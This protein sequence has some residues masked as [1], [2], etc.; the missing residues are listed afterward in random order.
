M[1][2]PTRPT[3]EMIEQLRRHAQDPAWTESFNKAFGPNA[4]R[5]FLNVTTST[6][7]DSPAGVGADVVRSLGRAGGE[8]LVGTLAAARPTQLYAQGFDETDPMFQQIMAD[9][10]E[11]ASGAPDA[12]GLGGMIDYE[13]QT[14]PGK[15]AYYAA[16]FLPL[17]IGGAM[18]GRPLVAG[19]AALAGA[20]TDAGVVEW[21]DLPREVG[22]VGGSIASM[23]AG[24]PMLR[25]PPGA[26][27]ASEALSGVPE[28]R[29]SDAVALQRSSV[30]EGVPL[31]APEALNE[32]GVIALADAA[33]T[34]PGAAAPFHAITRERENLAR[35]A[36]QTKLDQ[37]GSTDLSPAGVASD[38]TEAGKLIIGGAAQD[39]TR[40][41][42]TAG[43][44]NLPLEHVGPDRVTNLAAMVD[45][46]L[47]QTAGMSG[48]KPLLQKFRGQ[49]FEED[50]SPITNAAYLESAYKQLREGLNR[51][52]S[53]A[54]I[55]PDDAISAEDAG[56]VGPLIDEL[57]DILQEAP[58]YEPG[59]STF[60]SISESTVDPLRAQLEPV[61]GAND[62]KQIRTVMLDPDSVTA[63]ELGPLL[64]TVERKSPSAVPNIARVIFERAYDRAF[65]QR[66]GKTPPTSPARFVDAL[67]N[68][69]I[70]RQKFEEVVSSVAR[71]QGKNPSQV[72]AGWN[73]LLDVLQRTATMPDVGSRTNPRG[74]IQRQAGE[75]LLS[76]G[77][78][79]A[80]PLQVLERATGSRNMRRLGAILADSNGV[81]GLV[82]L[83]QTKPNTAR[84]AYIVNALLQTARVIENA[85]TEQ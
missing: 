8:M 4:A 10:A 3:P 22:S 46:T 80:Q 31:M 33:A 19:G 40:A 67:R 52:T 77:I 35:R 53:G 36:I 68:N 60:E 16:P 13:P 69:G 71:S 29:L 42:Q 74:T 70:Q 72:V 17:A 32:P 47:A 76:Q 65:K 75:T 18:G 14:I 55:S 73:K 45:A 59:R 62:W 15:A 84:A 51:R 85:G 2:A 5:R 48:L 56:K 9:S 20:G 11:Q 66:G 81:Q 57:A 49:L 83:A 6:V 43:Y 23:I 54:L 58:S 21:L 24:A 37:T 34:Y 7:T 28:Q 30:E 26:R 39:R 78:N 61:I 79:L 38:M 1:V 44:S 63:K 50:G 41:A 12:V 64:Q 27:L 25:R 82:D